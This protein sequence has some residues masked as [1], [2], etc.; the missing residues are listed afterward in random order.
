[1]K[2]KDTLDIVLKIVELVAFYSTLTEYSIHL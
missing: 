2:F 1:M